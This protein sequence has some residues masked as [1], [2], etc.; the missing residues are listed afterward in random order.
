MPLRVGAP[1]PTLTRESMVMTL[2]VAAAAIG[3]ANQGDMALH[4]EHISVAL[5]RAPRLEINDRRGRWGQRAAQRASP[6]L[7]L[8]LPPACAPL[9]LLRC[10]Q[11]DGPAPQFH[12]E[13]I[14]TR[15][16]SALGCLPTLRCPPGNRSRLARGR[17]T[18]ARPVSRGDRG[19]D[20]SCKRSRPS[21]P[22]VA[23]PRFVFP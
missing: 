20:V 22:R 18:S 16:R 15:W 6:P 4:P 8:E 11:Q 23:P 12:K 1:L 10:G 2:L 19:A 9:L 17:D 13:D 3:G 5:P 21:S 14:R 7:V